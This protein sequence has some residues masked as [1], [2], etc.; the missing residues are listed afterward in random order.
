[1]RLRGLSRL[2]KI[3]RW[4]RY[5]FAHRAIIVFYH[6]IANL[7]RLSVSPE[8]FAE[9]LDVLTKYFIPIKLSNL[10]NHIYDGTLPKKAIVVTFD[11]G[12]ADNFWNAYP[13][14]KRFGVP[15]TIFVTTGFIGSNKEFLGDE[16]ERLI[17]RKTVMQQHQEDNDLK[18]SKIQELCLEIDG[19]VR[20]WKLTTEE[21]RLRAY[22]EIH[23][24]MK[25]LP[26]EQREAILE[27]LRLWVGASRNGRPE[28]RFMT[29]E[30]LVA[31][32]NEGL[33]EIGAHTVNH[34]DLTMIPPERQRWEI[35]MSKQH[36]E[37]WLG[38]VVDLFAYPYGHVNDVTRQIVIEAGFKAACSTK[39]GAVTHKSDPFLLPRI[40]VDDWDGER[41]L[42]R[43]L[44]V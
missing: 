13:L 43:L 35:T 10:I 4:I 32:G 26:P 24:L 11:D 29:V 15:A 39:R 19:R 25:P 42:R 16:L 12:Y 36:L 30:E 20:Q 3:V 5:N 33:V 44:E 8:K 23:D 17:L 1:M 41:F 27:Q 28:Y 38:R 34:P 2:R 9:H 6:R 22:H 21:E 40:R 37:E 18:V 7:S 14:L 31:I